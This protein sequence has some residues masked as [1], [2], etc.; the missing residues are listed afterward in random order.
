MLIKIEIDKK[1]ETNTRT[2]KKEIEIEIEIIITKKI[3]ATE[4][5]NRE[6]IEDMIKETEEA[7][8]HDLYQKRES[9]AAKEN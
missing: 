9:I 1:I 7:L 6:I 2:T 5:T 3:I 4:N 8:D